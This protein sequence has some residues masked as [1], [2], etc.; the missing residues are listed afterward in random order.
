MPKVR[1]QASDEPGVAERRSPATDRTAERL[2]TG[3]PPGVRSS[4][5]IE[6]HR[7][8]HLESDVASIDRSPVEP[9]GTPSV[10]A[11][12]VGR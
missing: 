3:A 9:T 5:S 8:R 2:E 7:R 12:G 6:R 11:P 4:G 1:L 10:G